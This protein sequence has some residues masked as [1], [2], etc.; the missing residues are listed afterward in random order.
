MAKKIALMEK[1]KIEDISS[2]I[3]K[4]DVFVY[5]KI[6]EEVFL[7]S[8][9]PNKV[10]VSG[11]AFTMAKHF[12]MKPNIW[13]PSY[14]TVLQL[15]N[16]VYEEYEGPGIR[17]E[18][19]VFLFA[20]GNDGCGRESRQKYPVEYTKWIAPEN[21]VPFRYKLSSDDISESLRDKYFGR[22]DDGKHIAYYFKKFD[23]KP[24]FKQQYTDG[25]PIDENIYSSERTDKVD[26]YVELKMS[27]NRD[28]CR[29]FYEATTGLAD[30]RVS[31]LSLL[32]A[33]E[34]EI[35][36]HIYYQDIRPLTKIHFKNEDLD[37]KDKELII[38]YHIY[39]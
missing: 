25:T 32:T 29:E 33:W 20:M 11:S 4:T 1:N 35:D 36:G 19:Q 13:T 17:K 39:Y 14:N 37:E 15:D 30:A 10:I 23:A 12:N 22:K 18:E 21:L 38:V 24:V 26:S 9:G 31:S 6:G 7:S 3:P 34:K 16:S 27:I 28:D 8:R 2:I 5:N